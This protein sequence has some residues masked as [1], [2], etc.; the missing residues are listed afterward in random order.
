MGVSAAGRRRPLVRP[1][2]NGRVGDPGDDLIEFTVKGN[3]G[4]SAIVKGPIRDIDQLQ[5]AVSKLIAGMSTGEDPG[6]P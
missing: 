3:F 2:A 5:E 1:G 6:T 4:V